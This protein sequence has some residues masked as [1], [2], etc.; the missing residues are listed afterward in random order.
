[1]KNKLLY[2]LS[3]SVLLFSC[4]KNSNEYFDKDADERLNIK[5]EEYNS[6]LMSN[7]NGWLLT[8]N[9]NEAGGINHWVKFGDNNRVVMLSDVETYL[10]QYSGSAIT[11]KESSYGIKAL[12]NI[13]LLFDTYNYLHILSDPEG[14]VNGGKNGDGLKSD[15]EFSILNQSN[16]SIKSNGCYYLKGRYYKNE[17]ILRPCTKE[18]ADAIIAGGLKSNS[19]SFESYIKTM[20]VP[21]IEYNGKKAQLAIT[22]RKVSISYINDDGKIYEQSVGAILGMESLTGKQPVSNLNLFDE[23]NFNESK[24]DSL[25]FKDGKLQVGIGGKAVPVFDNKKPIIPLRLGYQK[26]FAKLDVDPSKLANTLVNPFLS[27][28][29]MYS[30]DYFAKGYAGFVLEREYLAFILIDGRPCMQMSLIYRYKGSLYSILW[31]YDYT[32][33]N[34]GTITFT[35]RYQKNAGATLFEPLLRR[36]PDYFCK[37]TYKVYNASDATK[38][39]IDKVEPRTFRIDWAEN[40]TEG[41]KDKVGGFY[42]IDDP[43]C[44]CVGL[45]II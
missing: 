18:V 41:L 5:M 11:Q 24:I 33:N 31:Y 34:D 43:G 45:L 38:I 2:I 13:T 10:P 29:F 32:M 42:P 19:A 26:D 15:F 7:K 40:N 17:A 1:M 23:L 8:V 35:N 16:T 39:V 9:S 25:F 20:K 28:I 30:R 4:E 21:A 12:Q 44:F 6:S 37:V 27:D 22:P 14:S 3:L 36:L